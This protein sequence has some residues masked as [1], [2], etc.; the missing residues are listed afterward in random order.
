MADQL[1]IYSRTAVY[2]IDLLS[3][4]YVLRDGSW[5]TSTPST[6]TD[7]AAQPYGSNP[8]FQ[9]F[10]EQ[11]ETMDLIAQNTT[12]STI[13]A[14]QQAISQ[15][16]EG[17]RLYNQHPTWTGGTLY[18]TEPVYLRWAIDGE[19]TKQS[20]IYEG[21]LATINEQCAEPF[22]SSDVSLVR[23][24]LVRHPFWE[25]TSVSV[26]G[27]STVDSLGGT[28]SFNN[29]DGDVWARIAMVKLYG[30]AGS[31]PLYRTWTGIREEMA[32]TNHFEPVWELEDGTEDPDGTGSAAFV[33]DAA[34]SGTGYVRITS[35]ASSLT[36]YHTMTVA[37]AC[38]AGGHSD[39]EQQMGEYLVLCR[40]R[41]NSGTAGLQM[42]YGYSSGVMFPAEEVF[43]TNTS[44]RLLE[45][46]RVK[47]PPSDIDLG[48][49]SSYMQWA[50]IDI[51]AEQVSGTSNLDLDA[52]VFV[53]T[54]HFW[55]AS[56]A[57]VLNT[58][59][60]SADIY[61]APNDKHIC[62][63]LAAS[64]PRY[65]LEYST[66]NWYL[67]TGDSIAVVAGERE[68][69]HVLADDVGITAQYFSRWEMY[70]T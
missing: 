64:R 58:S 28:F 48:T 15:A 54:H 8:A 44:W 62:L 9:N 17:A 35:P 46:G 63:G 18:A 32:G 41:V 40:C 30:I 7:Y 52:L 70:R 50:A 29:V 2:N 6:S 60:Y 22:I 38:S 12:H 1:E 68:T 56:G 26:A 65:S 5:A 21:A 66:D 3:G 16:L 39:Y 42:R 36:R 24:A 61:T 4:T 37:M 31:G 11:V 67:P 10:I 34:A 14:A 49:P 51:Y 45:L 27:A 59:T 13:Q 57:N 19:S 33:P 20:L 43:V 47:W 69:Q 25:D 23:M 53:P 55:K